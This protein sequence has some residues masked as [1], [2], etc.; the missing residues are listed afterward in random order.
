MHRDLLAQEWPGNTYSHLIVFG[1]VRL[2]HA[3]VS[4]GLAEL[5]V[6]GLDPVRMKHFGPGHTLGWSK[7]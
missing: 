3:Q 6:V 7:K 4:G 1:K 5:P 2:W